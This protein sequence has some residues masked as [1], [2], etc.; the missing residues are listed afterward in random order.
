MFHNRGKRR[1]SPDAKCLICG[2]I[3]ALGKLPCRYLE[4]FCTFVLSTKYCIL[5]SS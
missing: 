1:G 4:Y 2:A 5:C 3:L